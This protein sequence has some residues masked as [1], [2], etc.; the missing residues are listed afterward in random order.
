MFLLL[1]LIRESYLFAFQAI[2]A[3]KLRTLLSLS[4][5]TIGI[6]SVISVFT[7]FDS[8][9][10]SIRDSL[11][12]LGSNIIFVQKWP[13]GTMGGE[14][15]WWKYLNR[16]EATLDELE[17]IQRRANSVEAA[18]FMFGSNRTVKRLNNSIKN[19]QITAIS[20]DYEKV[21]PLDIQSGRYFTHTESQAGRNVAIIGS[22]IAENLFPGADPIGRDMKVFGSKLVVIGVLSSQGEGTFGNSTDEQV[23]VPVNFA[24]NYYNIRNIGTTIM[25]KGWSEVSNEQLKDE[26]TGIMRSLRK[27]KPG[28]ENN[29]ALNEVS[30][31]D[32][33]LQVF[34]SGLRLI[35]FIIG[36]FSLLVGAFGIAN[37]MFVSV[38]ERTNI[39][40]IQKAIGAKKY[41]ILL[42][43]LFEAVFLSLIG[44]IAGLILIFL[45]TLLLKNALPFPLILSQG[46]VIFGLAISTFIGLLAG[47]IPAWFASRLDPVE[48]IRFGI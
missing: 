12:D 4:G 20:H 17:D 29:F 28:E 24:R 31:I 3:N 19:V 40:G 26:L 22:E 30:A 25:V 2:I 48:A 33:N 16:P 23:F 27:Q 41:F 45:G 39:I 14:Y 18:A 7:V 46:N 38:R 15:P 8:L 43:F 35:G 21:M 5:I 34:F 32:Q 47:I 9:E 10:K 44:G 42:E 1:K 36:G 6:F 11:S 37:I 13:W